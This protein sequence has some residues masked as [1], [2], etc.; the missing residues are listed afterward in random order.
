MQVQ[1]IIGGGF[2]GGGELLRQLRVRGLQRG[3]FALGQFQ[4]GG[5]FLLHGLKIRF[6]AFGFAGYG[7]QLRLELVFIRRDGGQ[8]CFQLRDARFQIRGLFLQR[9]VVDPKI[10]APRNGEGQQNAQADRQFFH[11]PTLL[12]ILF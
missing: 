11:L 8:I 12:Y 7:F 10:R 1:L 5:G 9:T 4:R 2:G 6:G 3:L